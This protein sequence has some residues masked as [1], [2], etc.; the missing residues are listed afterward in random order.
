[1]VEKKLL[2]IQSFLHHSSTRRLNRHSKVLK[3]QINVQDQLVKK[4]W[5]GMNQLS[6]VEAVKKS[7]Q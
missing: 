3:K 5:F 6:K 2:L 4:K 1:M 7:S